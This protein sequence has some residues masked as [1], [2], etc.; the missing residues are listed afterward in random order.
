MSFRKDVLALKQQPANCIST[1]H[2]KFSGPIDSNHL[3]L[4]PCVFADFSHSKISLWYP[5]KPGLQEKNASFFWG[6]ILRFRKYYHL[7]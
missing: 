6:V 2:Q 5:R 3:F 4:V 7:P 1:F